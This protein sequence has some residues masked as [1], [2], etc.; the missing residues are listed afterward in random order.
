MY[1]TPGPITGTHSAF[2]LGFTGKVI[3]PKKKA[4]MEAAK[5]K[6]AEHPFLLVLLFLV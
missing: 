5:R 4:E 3:N 2:F 1:L 6:K